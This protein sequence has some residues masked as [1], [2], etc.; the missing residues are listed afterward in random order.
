M[1]RIIWI[2]VLIVMTALTACD[3]NTLPGGVQQYSINFSPDWD[4][5]ES[6]TYSYGSIK[7]REFGNTGR[8]GFGYFQTLEL[9]FSLKNGKQYQEVIELEPLIEKMV[10][11]HDLP[12][13]RKHDF[14]GFA[15]LK[16]RVGNSIEIK[17]GLS[18]K[19]FLFP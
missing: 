7:D 14:G 13:L 4:V 6:G 11:N 8:G 10:E 9:T 12:D 18:I 3:D 5:F 16:I 19:G 17:Y 15:K 1:K 2:G